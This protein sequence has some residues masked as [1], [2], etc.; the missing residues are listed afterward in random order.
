MALA[1]GSEV[2]SWRLDSH[3]RWELVLRKDVKTRVRYLAVM[4]EAVSDSI[5]IL[6][7]TS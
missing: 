2:Q 4:A 1:R 3:A 7:D 6:Q 5:E